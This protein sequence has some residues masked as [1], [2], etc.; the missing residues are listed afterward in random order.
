MDKSS[1]EQQFRKWEGI[2]FA[3]LNF[4]SRTPSGT[5]SYGSLAGWGRYKTRNGTER[6][7]LGRAPN[8]APAVLYNYLLY[9]PTAGIP[10]IVKQCII[11]HPACDFIIHEITFH[12]LFNARRHAVRYLE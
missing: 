1:S 9:F 8:V 10:L 4:W 11:L 7:Q 2:T 6:N 5:R 3:V 12:S